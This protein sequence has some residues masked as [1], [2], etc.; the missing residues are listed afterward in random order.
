M[1][2]VVRRHT[3][4]MLGWNTVCLQAVGAEVAVLAHESVLAKAAINLLIRRLC[5]VDRGDKEENQ[6]YAR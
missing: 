6:Q 5:H 1:N 2:V 3:L 4:P